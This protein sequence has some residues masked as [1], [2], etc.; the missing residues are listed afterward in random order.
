MDRKSVLGTIGGL[1]LGAVFGFWWRGSPAEAEPASEPLA[2]IAA[3]PPVVTVA[4]PEP[5]LELPEPE[6]EPEMLEPAGPYERALRVVADYAGEGVVRCP[7]GDALPEG[8]VVGIGRARV[9]NG[10]LV[11]SVEEPSG[12]ARLLLP[13]DPRSA[14]P[15]L[16]L[17]WWDAWPGDAGSCELLTPEQ[18]LVTG[19]VVDAQGRGVQSEVGNAV[20]GTVATAPDGTFTVRCWRGAECPLAARGAMGK[21]WGPFETLVVEGPSLDGI[22]LRLDEAPQ[23]DLR[24]YLQDQVAEDERLAKQPDPLRLAL[25]D[26]EL[27][28]EARELIEAWLDE[29]AEAR[30]IAKN[31]LADVE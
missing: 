9:E 8:E 18:V 30:A 14:A 5:E 17:R 12:R 23:R 21:P 31:L 24:A 4:S 15:R 11:G 10:V 22:E 29:Q 6:P 27:P 26:P 7:V 16:V 1:V 28:S 3:P 20:D 2:Q 19:R 13:S 25:S